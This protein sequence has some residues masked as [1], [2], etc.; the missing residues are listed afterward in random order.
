[1][2]RYRIAQK[3]EIQSLNHLNDIGVATWIC[4][5]FSAMKPSYVAVC[6]DDI[7]FVGSEGYISYFLINNNKLVLTH[8]SERTIINPNYRGRG[9]FEKLVKTCDE[10]AINDNS[11]FSWGATS[12]LKPFKKAGFEGHTEFRNYVFFPIRSKRISK[13]ISI[14]KLA[15]FNPFKIY[16]ILKRRDLNKIKS[17]VSW[18]S[19][20]KPPSIKKLNTIT[21]TDFNYD[22]VKDLI[23]QNDKSFF[24]INPTDLF[25]E[26]LENKGL[27]YEKLLIKENQTIIGYVILKIDTSKNYCSIVDIY[28]KSDTLGMPQVLLSLSKELPFQPFD[29]FFLALNNSNIVHRNWLNTLEKSKIINLKKAGS[30]VIK[31]LKNK[32][33]IDDLLLTDLWLE[34]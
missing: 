27:Y 15:I 29:A 21:F 12:A 17:F 32:V 20:F 8:R 5:F 14:K 31:K 30:F 24:K 18:L 19:L 3:S 9:L 6:S 1:M 22:D 28:L 7:T 34:L 11:A 4:D 16:K 33:C 10:S 25:F 26:W 13:I 2:L 23:F